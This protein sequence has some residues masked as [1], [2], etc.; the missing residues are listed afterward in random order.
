MSAAQESQTV[1][2]TPPA[3][4]ISEPSEGTV[5]GTSAAETSDPRTSDTQIL[6]ATPATTASTAPSATPISDSTPMEPAAD[7]QPAGIP[8]W[9]RR[10]PAAGSAEVPQDAA[11]GDGSNGGEPPLPPA[12][13]PGRPRRR[14]KGLTPTALLLLGAL[15]GG[16]VGG[17]VAY[18][19]TAATQQQ[20]TSTS[21]QS[22]SITINNPKSV[23]S[24]TA[25]AAKAS[26][27]VVTI[28]TVS[29]QSSGTG[30]GVIWN[31]DG[32]IVTNNHVVTLDGETSNPTLTVTL[33]NGKQY[34]AKIVGL[35]S[36]ADLAVIRI[37][38]TGLTPISLGNS[39]KLN[40]G[41]Q[42]VALGAPLGLSNSVTDGIV[43]ALHR[44]ISV[45]SSAA[46]EN[47]EQDSSGDG[48]PFGFWGFGDGGSS[49]D[50][51]ETTHSISLS[52]IQTDASI[53]PGNSGGALVD[54][55]GK[56]IGINVAIASAS[57]SSSSSD[58]TS[59]SIGVGFAIPVN[60]VQRVVNNLI[61]SGK[62]PHGLLGATISDTTTSASVSGALVRSVVS[63]GPAEQGGLQKGDIITAVGSVSVSTA[64]DLTA[65]VRS[66]A[67]GTKVTVHYTRGSQQS[68][69][70]VTLG[71][72]STD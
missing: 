9:L 33:S 49:G 72:A 10:P 19:L 18:G 41:D 15:T 55:S 23:N 48:S 13:E 12:E 64:T 37:N 6:G 25:A 26:P 5:S 21:Q 52:V 2:V 53:N 22:S 3:S 47:S 42:A 29:G 40:V 61:D 59:G 44:G 4:D 14:S 70:E 56:L 30:S 51:T 58:S 46:N 62:S 8:E 50:S 31:D 11:G 20:S 60:T 34:S 45:A 57:S 35:D 27:S 28:T 67:P 71:T 1:P 38:A 7:A 24:I 66:L 43:S 54:S 17:G 68:T 63:N 65:Y 16:V 36:E 69:A 32:D 39:D